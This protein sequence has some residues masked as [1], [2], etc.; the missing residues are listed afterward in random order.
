MAGRLP[1]KQETKVRFLLPMLAR[2]K[3]LLDVNI[4]LFST[5]LW[6]HG[7]NPRRPSLS[8]NLG[9]LSMIPRFRMS[10][11][12]GVSGSLNT[13]DPTCMTTNDYSAN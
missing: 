2:S 8:T 11:V 5:F 7:A 6:S 4:P 13:N 1:L 10:E 3:H 12:H 9:D